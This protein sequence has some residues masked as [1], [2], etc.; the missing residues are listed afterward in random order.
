MHQIVREVM[1]PNPL[2]ISGASAV[3]EAARVMRDHDIGDVLVLDGSRLAG[4]LTDRDVVVRGVAE[5]RDPTMTRAG[6]ICSRVI[7]TVHPKTGVGEAVRLMREH[8]IR[9]LPVVDEDGSVVGIV[10]LGDLAIDIDR[11]SVLAQI[12]AAPPNV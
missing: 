3:T 10:S 2:T 5:E 9:R 12:S 7:T 6:D 4:I 1:T 8:A 11:P